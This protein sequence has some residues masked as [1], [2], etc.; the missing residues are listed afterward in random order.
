MHSEQSGPTTADHPRLL[1]I[2]AVGDTMLGS[3][4]T[5]PASPDTYFSHVKGQLR[6]DIVFGNLEGTL[7]ETSDSAKC[8]AGATEC[9]AFKAPPSFARTLRDAGFTAMNNANNHSYDFGQTGQDDTVAAL[10]RV[11]IEQ[12]GLPGEITTMKAGGV[13]VALIGFAPYSDTASLTDLSTARALIRNAT[14]RASVV[15]CAIH[16]GAEG[17]GA[18]HVTG[19]EEYYAGED[20]GNPER[21]AHMAIDAGADLVLGSGPHVLRGME[22]YKHRLVAY[23]LGNFAGYYNFATDGV[24]GHSVILHVTLDENGAFH[25]GQLTSVDLMESG[26]P[27]ADPSGTAAALLASLAHEDLGFRAIRLGRHDR[28]LAPG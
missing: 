12:T 9:F 2:A 21:F 11:G 7:T 6:G 13:R 15:I 26:Q 27:A 24:L 23:S 3:T 25:A 16:A 17:S 10:H 4:P 1:T 22:I 8:S 19:E 18:L 20:R 28:I 14:H 5:L